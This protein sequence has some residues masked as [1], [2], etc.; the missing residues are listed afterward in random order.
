MS[1]H[2]WLW[3]RH[4]RV[5]DLFRDSRST[6][7]VCLVQMSSSPPPPSPTRPGHSP[8]RQPALDHRLPR[9]RRSDHPT[10]QSH[11]VNRYPQPIANARPL[12]RPLTC[13]GPPATACPP[14]YST[15][16]P[17]YSTH[18][19]LYSSH[20]PLYSRHSPLTLYELPATPVAALVPCHELPLHPPHQPM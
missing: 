4:I 10:H 9:A 20:S 8:A 2:W 7:F 15:H 19:P 1:C 14:L 3:S 5:S 18:P 12:T 13:H 17:L 6:P 11:S 16:S